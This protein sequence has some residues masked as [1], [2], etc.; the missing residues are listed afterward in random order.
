MIYRIYYKGKRKFALPIKT[1]EELMALRNSKE[2]LANLRKAQ[3]GD[4]EAKALLE[5]L[6]YNIGHVDGALAGCKSQG[7]FFF[8]DIDCYSKEQS[9]AYK[10]LILSKAS[11]IG[12]MMLERSAS[13]GWHLV[14]KRMKGTTILENQ[15]R[16]AMALMIEMDTNAH[17]LQRVVYSTSGS[18]EEN[19]FTSV[20]GADTTYY[21]QT[22]GTV[23][24]VVIGDTWN[25]GDG[26]DSN[27]NVFIDG[28]V[29][30]VSTFGNT[31]EGGID[32][33]RDGPVVTGGMVLAGGAGMMQESWAEGSTQCCAVVYCDLQPGDTPITIYDESGNEIWTA[34]LANTFNCFILSHPAL[35]AGHVYT[36]DYGGGTETLDFTESNNIRVGS[37]SSGW[38]WGFPGRW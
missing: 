22:G 4:Q 19:T 20:S 24:L 34:T 14:C 6:A 16:V 25:C 26:I 30:T 33:G 7:S 31:Q 17:D 2:N 9:E 29:L 21:R 37:S 15:V 18:E 8:H 27:G 1:R 3:K 32:T 38:G 36:V 11:E 12:L 10:E 23:D 28:G 13:G 35:E 5:Q